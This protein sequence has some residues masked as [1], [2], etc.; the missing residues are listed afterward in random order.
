MKKYYTR[1]CNFFYGSNSKYLVKKKII[2]Y[3]YVVVNLYHL[4]KLKFFTEKK[5]VNS[6]IIDIKNIKK[7]SK[8]IK[9]NI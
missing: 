6:K 1:A 7:L 2:S 8:D 5:K 4:I 9:K 3:L